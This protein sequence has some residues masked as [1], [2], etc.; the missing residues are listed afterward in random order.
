MFN[1]K[2]VWEIEKSFKLNNSERWCLNTRCC[3]AARSLL[4]ANHLENDLN[5]QTIS[6]LQKYSY[7]TNFF[8]FGIIKP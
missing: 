3:A 5:Q 4:T 7:L 6:I 8:T 2:D 1:L